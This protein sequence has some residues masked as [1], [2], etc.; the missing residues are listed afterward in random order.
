MKIIRI[1]SFLMGTAA[2]AAS[3]MSMEGVPNMSDHVEHR[4]IIVGH[5]SDTSGTAIEHIRV[6]LNDGEYTETQYSNSDGDFTAAIWKAEEDIVKSLTI[7]LE[8]ID[9]EE[10]GGWF[11]SLSET[12][13][14]FEDNSVT[15]LD[16]RLNHA[17]ASENIPQS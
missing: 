4:H 6:T 9:E 11:E 15:T 16:F 5:V 3:C 12:F 10:N 8:D 7:T 2:L 17:T 1:I 13:T 14:V